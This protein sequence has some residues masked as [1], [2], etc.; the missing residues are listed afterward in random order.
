MY[1]GPILYKGKLSILERSSEKEIRQISAPICFA[2]VFDVHDL[3]H[4]ILARLV[5]RIQNISARI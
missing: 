3:K 2:Y 4:L 5:F 1:M